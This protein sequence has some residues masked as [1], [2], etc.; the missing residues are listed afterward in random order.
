MQSLIDELSK[1]IRIVNDD[2]GQEMFLSRERHIH[3]LT[4][5]IDELDAFQESFDKD[6]GLAAQNLKD[7]SEFIGEIAGSVVS[8]RILDEIFSN[9]CIGK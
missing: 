1:R 4:R 2:E 3:L 6:I 7:A 5:A 8:E 9:F